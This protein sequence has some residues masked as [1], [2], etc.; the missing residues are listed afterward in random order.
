MIELTILFGLALGILLTLLTC[1]TIRLLTHPKRRTAAWA[2]ARSLPADPEDLNLDY[3]NVEIDLEDGPPIELW[4]IDLSPHS[5]SSNSTAPRPIII[6]LHGWGNSRI[7]NLGWID[8]IGPVGRRLLTFDQRGHGDSAYPTCTWGRHE[9]HDALAVLQWAKQRYPQH[10]LILL[11]C[12]M[13]AEYALR[14]AAI[15]PAGLIDGLV[16]DSPYRKIQQV[17]TR[18]LTCEGVPTWP[19]LPIALAWL[20]RRHPSFQMRDTLKLAKN[21]NLPA[22]VFHGENDSMIPVATANQ[23]A[24]ALN[25]SCVIVE[26]AEHLRGARLN[27]DVYQQKLNIF[28]N[29]MDKDWG[30]SSSALQE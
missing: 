15:A 12:S 24:T 11:G 17:M 28:F 10:P 22:I 23:I 7:D 1:L 9:P 27:P 19:N 25:A 8:A 2:I 13:G 4:D 5:S 20:A 21:I 29:S 30:K 18:K 26:D 14:T 3:Q 6:M 16:L